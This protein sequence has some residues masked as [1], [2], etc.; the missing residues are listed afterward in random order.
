MRK[1]T[2]KEKSILLL[3]KSLGIP[4]VRALYKSCKVNTEGSGTVSELMDKKESFIC[5][6]WHQRL[7]LVTGYFRDTGGSPLVSMS[8]E[9]E[10]IT[11]ALKRL[12]YNP[13]RGSTSRRSYESFRELFAVLDK[14]TQIGITPDGPRGPARCVQDGV[15]YLAKFSG[16]PIIP[17]GA[18]AGKYWIFNSWDRFIVPK[19]AS[20]VFL[21]FGEPMY[22]NKDAGKDEIE[23]KRDEL[24]M[25]LDELCD[26]VDNN[27]GH[28]PLP[29]AR[30]R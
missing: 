22:I 6:F 7:F 28:K 11:T 25:K 9:G 15:L 10:Y 8:R 18:S 4:A 30:V 24:K 27:A 29:S 2:L 26:A 13:V 20:S 21:R 1:F 3:I 23:S 12:G 5:V 16:R 14:G 19:P 17:V